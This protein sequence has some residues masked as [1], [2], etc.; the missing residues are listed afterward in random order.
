[1]NNYLKCPKCKRTEIKI[2]T[3]NISDTLKRKSLNVV[4]PLRYLTGHSNKPKT[5]FVCKKCGYSW[6]EK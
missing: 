5:L 4:M 3:E 2:I 6:K 1:M